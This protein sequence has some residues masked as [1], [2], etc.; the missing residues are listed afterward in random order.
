M[1]PRQTFTPPPSSPPSEPPD[2]P[3]T[4]RPRGPAPL[5]LI[6]AEA[7]RKFHPDINL[8]N[9]F[10]IIA[11]GDSK[12]LDYSTSAKLA[13]L[14]QEWMKTV[15]LYGS[16]V[17]AMRCIKEFLDA[18]VEPTGIKPSPDDPDARYL[19]IPET[20][21][22][23]RFW[24]GSLA[25]AEYCIDF[26]ETA[27]KK[28][29]NVPDGYELWVIP[30]PT[31]PWLTPVTMQVLSIERIHGIDPEDIQEGEEKFILRDGLYCQLVR[32]GHRIMRFRIPMRPQAFIAEDGLGPILD[33]E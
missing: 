20:T 11:L 16:S 33:P 27:T 23:L 25:D 6:Y 14:D 22:S 24:P 26:V 15:A 2:L 13:W 7:A 31:A 28:P 18:L 9:D 30:D 10:Q 1:E 12:L 8:Q 5:R 19:R 4:P 3:P 21:W 17:T 29:L 32:D